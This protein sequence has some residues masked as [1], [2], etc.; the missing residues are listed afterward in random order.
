MNKRK[1]ERFAELILQDLEIAIELI[2][3]LPKKEQRELKH[4]LVTEKGIRSIIFNK[5]DVVRAKDE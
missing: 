3:S 4:F 1:K 2:N 5:V